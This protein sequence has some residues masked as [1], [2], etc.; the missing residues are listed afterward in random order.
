MKQETVAMLD[1]V[2]VMVAKCRAQ[3]MDDDSTARVVDNFLTTEAE[4]VLAHMAAQAESAIDYFDAVR[5][6]ADRMAARV[7]FVGA[8][9]AARAESKL[10]PH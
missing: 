8:H 1:D 5:A 2:K 9:L 3:G 4:R 7:D 10:T 6:K